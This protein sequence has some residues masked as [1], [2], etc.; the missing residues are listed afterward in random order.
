MNINLELYK[1]FY[2]VAKY[3]SFTEAAKNLYISQ[4]A[5]TQ[6]INTLEKQLNCRL[7]YR[8]ANGVKLT[9]DGE[10]L[11]GDIK[12]SMEIIT[13]IEDKFNE[14]RS[15]KTE[16]REIKIQTTTLLNNIYMYNKM[17]KFL[18]KNSNSDVNII[19]E[20]NIKNAIEELSNKEIDLAVF[21]YP[22][23]IRK[24]HIETVLH[25]KLEQ[26]LYASKGYLD[27]NINIYKQNEYKFILP[28]KDTLERGKVDK[29]FAKNNI[30]INS[31]YEIND[32]NIRKSLVLNNLG[33][34]L[35]IK[36]ILQ[37]ELEKGVFIEIPLK[38]KLPTYDIYI[39]KLKNNKEIEKFLN[40]A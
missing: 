39:A 17:I 38:E 35:G 31:S 18:K 28:N 11:F 36:D 2:I 22:Y 33:I 12:N 29:Y 40:I 24:N 9:E 20:P 3:K 13:N 1:M 21:D 27:G 14:Y 30:Y 32:F 7:F 6:R 4:P 34:A 5:I 19:Y 37:N 23:K 25:A 16:K 8:L 15:N 26:I 10:K